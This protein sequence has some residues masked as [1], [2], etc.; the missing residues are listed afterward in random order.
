MQ[1][2]LVLRQCDK[3]KLEETIPSTGGKK[4]FNLTTIELD[5]KTDKL[6][7]DGVAT[8][9]NGYPSISI[10][11]CDICLSVLIPV[12]FTEKTLMPFE[13]LK[14]VEQT[15]GERLEEI[16]REIVTSVIPPE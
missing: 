8:Y 13:K 3:C 7:N 15:M 9:L 10:Q 5:I 11:V 12:T 2:Q 6:I 14:I 16:I 4:G 1:K